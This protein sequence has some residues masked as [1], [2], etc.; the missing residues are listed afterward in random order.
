MNFFGSCKSCK[1]LEGT[2]RDTQ[3]LLNEVMNSTVEKEELVRKQ[4]QKLNQL[5]SEIMNKSGSLENTNNEITNTKLAA[6]FDSKVKQGWIEI[7]EDLEGDFSEIELLTIMSRV[8]EIVFTEC[9]TV[10]KRAD[11]QLF[12]S[13][14][15]HEKHISEALLREIRF[16]RATNG[17]NTATRQSQAQKILDRIEWPENIKT[18]I[19]EC[20]KTCIQTFLTELVDVCWLM[21]T[22]NPPLILNFDVKGKEYSANVRER[23]VQ[24]ATTDVISDSQCLPG[25]V[26]L[27][28]WPSV[29]L[30]D[31]SNYL[32]KGEVVVMPNKT[33]T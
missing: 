10:I 1:Q 2:I 33:Q 23:F 17:A 28:A 19:S 31:N 20:P 7:C 14:F 16:A 15:S 5:M 11:E 18:I 24:I 4:G 21:V 27:V 8:C 25:H 32:K 22:S 30:E 26:L 29:E 3:A 9:Q 12:E 6:K 13:I